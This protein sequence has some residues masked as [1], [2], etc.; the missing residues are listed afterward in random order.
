M[1]KEKLKLLLPLK[2]DL[3]SVTII[4]QP[5]SL[6][7]NSFFYHFDCENFSADVVVSST[8]NQN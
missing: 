2:K 8:N 6:R 1:D 5:V 7:R 4:G 3:F